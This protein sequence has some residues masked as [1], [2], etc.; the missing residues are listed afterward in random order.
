MSNILTDHGSLPLSSLRLIVPPLQLVSAALWEIVKQKA[1]MYYG[2]L[3][4]FV[5][6]VLE[7]VPELLNDAE[8]VQ[9]VMGLRAMVVLELCRNDDFASPQAIQPH[10]TRI[11]TYITKQEKEASSSEIKASVT[12]FVKLVHTLVDDQCQRDIFYQKIFPTV[13][14]PKYD[15][16]LQALMRKFLVSLQK[17]LPVPNLEQTSLWLSLSPSILKE[18]VEFM[19]EP[20]PL[21]TL[22]EHH[23]HHGHEVSQ[24]LSSPADDCIL[25]SLSYHLPKVDNDEGDPVS[26]LESKED[27]KENLEEINS[28]RTRIVESNGQQS[29]D[30][31]EDQ[32]ASVEVFTYPK[33]FDKHQKICVVA[34]NQKTQT[35]LQLSTSSS[36]HSKPNPVEKTKVLKESRA[37]TRYGVSLFERSLL[38]SRRSV[39]LSG[40]VAINL[41]QCPVVT[42]GR[43]GQTQN[44]GHSHSGR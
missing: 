15:S 23:K 29:V 41:N 20:E 33:N 18:C 25:S 34:S 40:E 44:R 4:E 30:Q 17:L 10:L 5:T 7:T 22:I 36:H 21:N 42:A 31:A 38:I 2:L 13:F 3:E 1:V 35:D 16:A 19:N 26:S 32:G 39:L 37:S 14:G 43:P 8:R 24:A 27:E 12:N 28:E 11:N 9:L 6:T